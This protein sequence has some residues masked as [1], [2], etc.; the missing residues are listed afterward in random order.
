[1]FD[2]DK[3]RGSVFPGVV[4][5]CA[6]AVL[7]VAQLSVKRPIPTTRVCFPVGSGTT[8]P[9]ENKAKHPPLRFNCNFPD[10]A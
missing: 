1:M 8:D 2:N 5:L 3:Q 9:R 10:R 6:M 4:I 7:L